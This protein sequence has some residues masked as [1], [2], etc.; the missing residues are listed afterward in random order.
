MQEVER[1]SCWWRHQRGEKWTFPIVVQC[2]P[3]RA[4]VTTSGGGQR[5]LRYSSIYCI[6]MYTEFIEKV[7]VTSEGVEYWK[8]TERAPSIVARAQQGV[9]PLEWTPGQQSPTN[10]FCLQ[11]FYCNKIL[12]NKN[13][14]RLR[15]SCSIMSGTSSS[16]SSHHSLRITRMEPTRQ[17]QQQQKSLAQGPHRT[18][19]SIRIRHQLKE[20]WH[21]N[22]RPHR[23][24]RSFCQLV[25]RVF[26]NF[27]AIFRFVYRIV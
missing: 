18:K 12:C 5:A 20:N 27:V 25:R 13:M 26:W 8:C 4:F 23:F 7:C 16:S 3:L 15:I 14:F 9:W 17:H 6:Y 10:T 22:I 24:G 1:G 21:G 19:I 11:C 2:K